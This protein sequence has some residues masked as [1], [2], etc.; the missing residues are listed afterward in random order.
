M[1][2]LSIDEIRELSGADDAE[3]LD[4][5]PA[6]TVELSAQGK[7]NQAAEAV[8]MTFGGR[9]FGSQLIEP[10]EVARVLKVG[11]YFLV[12]PRDEHDTWYMGTM[13]DLGVVRTWGSYGNLENALRSL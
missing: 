13:D 2:D 10:L 9:S 7:P 12:E 1:A 3:W 4:P 11:D 8:D 5:P 6:A